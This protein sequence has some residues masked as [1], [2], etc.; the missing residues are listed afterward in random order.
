MI[1]LSLRLHNWRQFKGTTPEIKFSLPG[2]TPVT[3]IYGTNG[4]GKTSILNAFTWTLYNST[5][6]G[7]LYPNQIVNK[8][9]IR[10]AELGD[11]V[12]A[13]VELKF[14]HLGNKYAIRKTVIAKR[15]KTESST[16]QR[17]D[18]TT[19]L[20]FCGPDGQWKA[21]TEIAESVGRVLPVDLHTY[22]FFDGERIERIV[23]PDSKEKADISN[24]T[25]KLLGLEVLERA[26][27]HLTAA[28]KKLE[29]EYALIGD[30]ETT[31]LLEEKK[32]I[33]ADVDNHKDRRHELNRNIDAQRRIKKDVEERQRQLEAVKGIQKRRDTLN[34]EQEQRKI[35]LKENSESLAGLIS[36]RGYTVHVAEACVSYQRIIEEKRARGELPAGIKRQFVDDLLTRDRCICDRSL[37]AQSYTHARNA[38]AAWRQ[39]AGLSDVEENAIRMGGEVKQLERQLSEFWTLTD[40]YE[41]RRASDRERISNIQREL[42]SIREDL[43]R[44]PKEKVSEL[45]NR[46]VA[47]EEA[48]E[49]A[50]EESGSR[51]VEISQKQKRIEKI[52]ADIQRHEANKERQRIARDRVVAARQS[53]IR[54]KDSKVRFE[55]TFRKHLLEKI[56]ALFRVISFAPY[57]PEIGDDYSLSLR[58]S[59]GGVPL[60][61][62]SSQG[63]SQILSLCFIGAVIAVAK[64]Y[65]ARKE[66]LPGPAGSDYPVVMDSPFGSLGP[67]Y[68]EQIAKNVTE[69]SD[70]VIILVTNTQWRGEVEK[71]MEDLIKLRYVLEYF[72]P[73]KDLPRETFDVGNTTYDLIKP[74]PNEYEYTKVVEVYHD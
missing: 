11:L 26:V 17:H 63:E 69:L 37:E 73:K 29:R 31:K 35:S 13:W 19:V 4:A 48:I 58:E 34:R 24:A 2:S 6:R 50:I 65:Q 41:Q 36:T 7:F 60:K 52:D 10:E 66:F 44:S 46:S 74:S 14:D 57:V 12:E 53:I 43:Q 33:E 40:E 15:G 38:V 23:R 28:R 59:A 20:Q 61:V 42:D 3:V 25:K 8:A 62:A 9:A 5:T 45:E 49:E 1:L 22:F 56:R 54:L 32:K 27:R 39:K 30:A 51:K 71:S 47:A 16:N 68:R 18:L 55:V 70:Q 67:T 64:E 21:V 72:S